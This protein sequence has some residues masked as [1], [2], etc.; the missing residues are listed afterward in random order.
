[1]E[2]KQL[3]ANMIISVIFWVSIWTSGWFFLKTIKKALLNEVTKANEEF[4]RARQAV[5]SVYIDPFLAELTVKN[6]K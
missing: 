4:K 5:P 6:P 3:I 1:M 2:N